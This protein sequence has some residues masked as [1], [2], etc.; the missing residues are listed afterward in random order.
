MEAARSGG[1]RPSPSPSPA[2]PRRAPAL[3]DG[4]RGRG[5]A[6]LQSRQRLLVLGAARG[7]RRHQCRGG[8]RSE[9]GPRP[10]A[11]TGNGPGAPRAHTGDGPGPRAHSGNAAGPGLTIAGSGHRERAAAAATSAA[12]NGA[13]PGTRR[14]VTSRQSR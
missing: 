3:G 9:G 4:A 8:H 10:G 12:I 2:V 13:A 1:A 11:H 14:K 5:R 7:A 6:P